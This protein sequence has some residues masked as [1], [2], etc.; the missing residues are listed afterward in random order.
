MLLGRFT[1]SGVSFWERLIGW[2]GQSLLGELI[3]YIGDKYFTVHFH[4]YEYMPFGP[5]F[6]DTARMLIFGIA[7]GMIIA[8]VMISHTRVKLGGFIRR[9]I[10]ENCL[11]PENA[12][13]LMEL[14]EFRNS[15]VRRELSKGVTLRKYVKCCEE[16]A[17]TIAQTSNVSEAVAND[18]D[19]KEG[20]IDIMTEQPKRHNSFGK[21][22]LAFFTSKESSDFRMDFT[23]MH[24][25][26]P[27]E[28]K[29]RADVR[30]EK[31]GSGRL[32][33]IL[34]CIGAVLFTALACRFLPDIIQMMD[35]IINQ[36][37]P[38]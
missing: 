23:K 12:K 37:A 21:K 28:L 2:Y 1:L 4:V 8:S 22:L 24:F 14:D 29:Y 31:K 19:A 17:Y 5:Q 13:T 9:L 25:Y 16:E 30:F 35:N 7:I 11:S 20:A 27:E 34:T 26:I 6:D 10:A 36:M 38:Q 3:R 32:P 18:D 33:V 15:A